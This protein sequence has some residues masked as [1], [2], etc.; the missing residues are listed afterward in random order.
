MRSSPSTSRTSKMIGM[1]TFK[2]TVKSV[3]FLKPAWCGTHHAGFS[4]NQD[5]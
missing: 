1:M 2:Q 4:R 3:Y 5:L